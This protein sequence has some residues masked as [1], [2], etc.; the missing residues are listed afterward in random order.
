MVEQITVAFLFCNW[1]QFPV[2]PADLLA[3]A[4]LA[5]TNINGRSLDISWTDTNTEETG[6]VVEHSLDNITYT[7]IA[8]LPAN[9]ETTSFTSLVNGTNYFKVYGISGVPAVPGPAV[10]GNLDVVLL[11]EITALS[12]PFNVPAGTLWPSP[13]SGLTNIELIGANQNNATSG[14]HTSYFYILVCWSSIYNQFS[15]NENGL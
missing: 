7:V 9:T 8:T 12:Y 14:L 1:Q 5:F 11:P 13:P 2:L 4:N 10:T 6:Y 15:V 3:P